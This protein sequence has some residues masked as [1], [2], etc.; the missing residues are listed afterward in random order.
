MKSKWLILLCLLFCATTNSFA[1]KVSLNY[2]NVTLEKVFSA[3]NDQTGLT[4]S[5]SSPTIDPTEKISV[6]ET[7]KDVCEVLNKLLAHK[8]VIAEKDGGRILLKSKQQTPQQKQSVTGVVSDTKGEGLPGVYVK[9]KGSDIASV[10]DSYGNFT[11]DANINDILEFVFLGMESEDYVVKDY[12]KAQIVMTDSSISLDELVVVAYGTT[13]KESY[14]GAMNV[15]SSSAMSERPVSSL[16]ETLGANV[17][18]ITVTSSGQPGAMPTVRIRGIGSMNAS[19]APLY[20]ID[21]VA[22]DMSDMAQLGNSTINPM[23]N[24]NPN[25]IESMTILKDAAAAS[26]YGSRA[27]NGVIII[28]TKQGKS[29]KMKYEVDVIHGISNMA[30]TPDLVNQDEF[31]EIWVT[32]YMHSLMKKQADK[33]KVNPWEFI[34]ES[35]AD[36]ASYDSYLGQARK[37]F[38]NKFQIEGKIYDFWGDGYSAYPNTNWFDAVSRRGTVDKVNVAVSGGRDKLTF[39]TSGEYYALN[40]TIQK[41]D[42]RRYSGRSNITSKV[43]DVLWLGVN[44][45]LSVTD[46]SGPQQDNMYA[47]PIRTATGIPPVV[48]VM[49]SDGTYNS[50]FA[51]AVF[52]NYNPA[53]ILEAADFTTLTYRTIGNAWAQL[54]IMEGLFFKSTFGY[55]MRQT[56]E[57]RWY[58][59]AIAAGKSANGQLAQ[60]LTSRRRL[61]T[62]NILNYTKDIKKHNINA[63]VGFEGQHTHSNYFGGTATNYQTNYTPVLNAG[64]VIKE[65]VGRNTDDALLSLIAKAEYNYDSRYYLSGSF[66]RDGSSRFAKESRWGNFWAASGAWRIS[67]E[68]FMKDISWISEAKIRASYG[69]NGTLPSGLY[70]YIGN[71][72]FGNDYNGESGAVITNVANSRLTWEESHNFDAGIDLSLLKGRINLTFDIF[73]RIS[74]NLLLDKELSRTSGYSSATVNLGKMSN[75]GIEVSLDAVAFDTKDFRWD[76]TLNLATL[77]NKIVELPTDNIDTQRIHREGFSYNSWYLV[78]WAGIDKTTGEPQWYH[79]DEATGKKTITKVF[80]EG[81]RQIF[82]G[83][84]PRF[85]GG[86]N[87]DIRYGSFDLSALFSFAWGFNV[88]DFDGARVINDDG[89]AASTNKERFVLDNWRPDNTESNNPIL[90]QSY[91]AGSN[92][93]TRY[94]HKGDYLKLKN[95]RLGYTFP[96]R[97]SNLV[98]INN[99]RLYIQGENLFTLTEMDNFDPEV[100]SNRYIYT[101]PSLT[102]YTLGL[103]ITF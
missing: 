21:G 77:E 72:G 51:Y 44:M 79:V 98:G 52:S 65:L 74:N 101:F 30:Y 59:Q 8:N 54:N 99:L 19:N 55:D 49:N 103:N 16:T 92:Y 80:A 36:K 81:T 22:S 26:L 60:Y 57:T 87:T 40:S 61:T 5:Y 48:P 84:L 20:V 97:I 43:S 13:K 38:N 37:E 95:I 25:D 46:V 90:V 71:Y 4:V 85:S 15:V 63:L 29:G 9:V 24:I 31:A 67:K 50:N 11:I 45:N 73:S 6:N 70:D 39:F 102:N 76:F 7:D 27:A 10:S 88:F 68:N 89:N 86:L 1:Q 56:E 94:L 69:I 23:A 34:K 35:Y 78:E 62:S 96:K 75:K 33:D 66:R 28:N 41:S 82:G 32:S 3:I 93:S 83:Y 12:S 64:S 2:Q 17:P 14:T 47:N 53:A 100:S 18:G 42:M 58:P 91:K